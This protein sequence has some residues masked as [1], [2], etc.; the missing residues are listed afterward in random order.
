MPLGEDPVHRGQSTPGGRGIDH[1][2]VHQRA[3]V[4]QLEGRE[5]PEHV[6]PGLRAGD[7]APT[8]V[9]ERGPQPF[10]A[11]QHELFDRFGEDRVVRADV[12][13]VSAALTQV[14]PQ[15]F[16]DGCGQLDG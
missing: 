11:A 1:V 8:P 4:Q 5:Q 3:R 9:G 6:G 14:V 7:G 2:V 13:R 15:L 12:R 10:A 16:V